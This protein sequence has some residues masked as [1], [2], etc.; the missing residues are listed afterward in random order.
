MKTNI[1]KRNLLVPFLK[2]IAD[3]ATI[4]LAVLFSY[5]LRF[6][7]PLKEI[8]PVTKGYPPLENYFYFSL[9]LA[10][11]MM[12]FFATMNAYRSRFFSTFT[13]D[14]PVIFKTCF[15]GIL[16][17]MSGAFL[18]RE[19][20]Y[21]RLV[22]VLIFL[23]TNIFLLAGRFIFHRLKRKFLTKGFNVLRVCL[24]G[25]VENVVQAYKRLTADKN[26][27]FDIT[28]YVA[29]REMASLAIPRIGKLD[30]L[31]RILE[32]NPDFD[33]MVITFNQHD[34]NKILQV[35]KAT[36]GKNIELFYIPDI[37]DLLTHKLHSGYPRS[38]HP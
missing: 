15:L 37:L 19:F 12:G 38:A 30:D 28:G 20:S 5:Y 21:S 34:H 1:Y 6:Y 26:Y 14:V 2:M 11:V 24:V 27:K 33:G 25:S 17:A 10:A 32:S 23:N 9:F 8:F 3:V 31:P 18:Y 16:F 22:F 29:E 4:E 35:I 7:S 13:Q 36:E